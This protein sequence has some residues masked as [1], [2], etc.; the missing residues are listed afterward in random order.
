MFRIA[1]IILSLLA[2]FSASSLNAQTWEPMSGPSRTEVRELAAGRLAG[3]TNLTMYHSTAT[4]LYRSTN[5]G[6]DWTATTPVGGNPLAITCKPD[7]PQVVLVG[8]QNYL[9]MSVDGGMT[10]VPKVDND[11]LFTPLRLASAPASSARMYLGREKRSGQ[12]SMSRSSNGGL[13]WNDVDYFFGNNLQTD[14]SAFGMHP[15]EGLKLWA[16]GSS[17]A[18]PEPAENFTLPYVNGVFYSIDGG[19]NWSNSGN[20]T[21]NVVALS[22]LVSGGTTT[23]FAG[24]TDAA[25]KLYKTDNNGTT[26][27]PVSGYNGGLIKDIAIYPGLSIWVAA[28]N[29]LYYSTNEGGSWTAASCSG[30]YGLDFKRVMYDFVPSPENRGEIYAGG[31]SNLFKTTDHGASWS[32]AGKNISSLQ[33]SALAANG[34]TLLAAPASYSALQRKSGYDWIATQPA[35]CSEEF[36]GKAIGFKYTTGGI[37]YAAGSQIVGSAMHASMWRSDNDGLSWFIV[38][39]LAGSLNGGVYRGFAVDP[40]NSQRLYVFGKKE[41]NQNI[42]VSIDGGSNWESVSF[43]VN[44]VAPEVAALAID[45]TNQSGGYSHTLYAA[46]NGGIWKS[47]DGGATWPTQF[48]VGSDV[49][50]MA[51]NPNAPSVLYAAGVDN[52]VTPW[53]NKTTNGGASWTLF[54]GI[55]AEVKDILMHPSYPNSN[56]NLFIIAEGGSYLRKTVNGGVNWENVTGNLAGQAIAL[57]ADLL[58]KAYVYALTTSGVYRYDD[59]PHVPVIST[60][61][62]YGHPNPT[63][64]S[65]EA[66]LASPA[67]HV[68]KYYQTCVYYCPG[69]TCG[70]MSTPIDLGTTSTFSWYD[71]TENVVQCG[72]GG[73]GATGL[74]GY[75]VDAYDGHGNSARSG[76]AKYYQGGVVPIDPPQ[77]KTQGGAVTQLRYFL[78][79]NYPNPFNPVTSIH[80]GLLEDSHVTFVV[81]DLLGREV[82]RLV[83]EFQKAGQKTVTVDATHL[84]SGVYVYKLTAGKFTATKKMVL[85]K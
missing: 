37:V 53:M 17:P 68:F 60:P 45:P 44:G 42:L 40:V 70:P 21:K 8:I 47:N 11:P 82:M 15:T 71:P 4:T 59:P 36:R 75:Y 56:S 81:Y 6:G 57:A 18:H 2:A 48:L 64:A 5:N 65:E 25:N 12:S 14:I 33:L 46:C 9:K 22:V 1:V 13:D 41:T 61:I 24:T 3:V 67:F 73:E 77:E 7:G 63:W 79:S 62:V 34:P 55:Y 49:R 85:M 66:D 80:Y 50:H 43:T 76:Y 58:G 39:A 30:R 38:S 16:G 10:W 72:G 19:V 84:A 26:W 78:G 51:L 32:D 74:V 23:I 54:T 28:D 69:K 29:G 31:A 27:T 20:L 83:D 52:G 35:N